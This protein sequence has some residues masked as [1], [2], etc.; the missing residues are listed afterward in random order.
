M[1][2]IKKITKRKNGVIRG[3]TDFFRTARYGLTL[4]EHR[5]IYYAILRGQQE[6]KPFEPVNL[7]ITEFKEL[8]ELSGGN[9]YTAIRN[10]SKKMAGR[11]VEVIYKDSEGP[12]FIQAPWIIGI[13]YHIKNGSVTIEPNKKLQPFFEG[14]PFTD[15]EFAF[16]IKF[17]SQYAERLYE[18]IKTFAYKSIADFSIEELRDK[19]AVGNKYPNYAHFKERVIQP[20]V[21]DINEFTDLDLDFREKRGMYNKVDS[22]VFSI[23]KKQVPKLAKR[24][25]NGEFTP[26]LSDEEQ[27]QMIAEMFEGQV[28]F[29]D[30]LLGGDTNE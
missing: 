29:D 21:N 18:L 13:T 24:I 3:K 16:L 4:Q 10:L 2:D 23:H 28:S 17:T 6:G 7:S 15:T 20:A 8:F 19:L 22:V 11:V 27:A 26:P 9:Y 1:T 30:L 12:H 14:K 5:I 25:E